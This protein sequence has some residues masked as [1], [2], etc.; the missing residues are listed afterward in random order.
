MSNSR[1]LEGVVDRVAELLLRRFGMRPDPTL[2]GRL[3]RAIRDKAAEHGQDLTA[4]FDALGVSGDIL[5]GLLNRVTVQET[6][7]FRHPEQFD[8]LARDVLPA[9][10]RPVRIWSAG[11]AN[12][13]EAFSLAMLLQEQDVDGCVMATDLSTAALQRTTAAR[14]ASRE[15]SGL[16]PDRIA[17]HMT[18][19][20]DSWE[21]NKLIRDRVS[22]LHYNLLD[23]LPPE[24][25][26][27]QIVFCRNVLIYLSPEHAQ[28]LLDRIADTL[29]STISL[30]L[31]AA[32]TI[33]QVSD[34]FKAIPAGDTFIYRRA[35][36]E[37]ASDETR[38]QRRTAPTD[39][40]RA[41]LK[42]TVRK[43]AANVV[44][45]EQSDPRSSGPLTAAQQS[46]AAPE[47]TEL[48]ELLA[49][50]GEDAM[51]AGDIP[52]AVVAF[53]KFAYLAPHDPVA[54][55]HLGLALEAAGDDRSAQRAY[56]AARRALLEA[57]P[58]DSDAGIKG[59]A[60]AEF[61]R[62][63]DSKQR[64]LTQ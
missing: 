33:W 3:R 47:S 20:G 19:T 23:P 46:T 18:P 30:F 15:L 54:Q 11:C 12:G 13:Q 45:G 58:A 38:P 22:T 6:A 41:P 28:A 10:Q 59:Y 51:A 5:Q 43:R 29:P 57:D 64:E 53:R 26:S 1:A 9:L 37:A 7:F 44:A 21:V 16:S 36:T 4:Y 17:S 25:R 39:S 60:T 14:Y 24:I 35:V 40:G 63:L 48:A 61:V 49:R 56:A 31:G 52:A 55:L 2:R 62:L 8:V 27:C 42:R 50:L 34:R 32:E